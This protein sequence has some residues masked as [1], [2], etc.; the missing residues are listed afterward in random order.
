MGAIIGQRL[1]G[2]TKEEFSILPGGFLVIE[3]R[4]LKPPCPFLVPDGSAK[5]E[6]KTMSGKIQILG[7][8]DLDNAIFAPCIFRKLFK[9]SVL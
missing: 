4:K 7:L 3:L 8:L 6:Q 1:S 9:F 2:G 5:K